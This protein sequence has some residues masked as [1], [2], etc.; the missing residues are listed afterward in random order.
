MDNNVLWQ[1][2]ALALQEKALSSECTKAGNT[3]Y[4]Q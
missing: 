2:L 3:E 4:K 1:L